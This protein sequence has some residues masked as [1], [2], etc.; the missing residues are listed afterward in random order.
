MLHRSKGE[1]GAVAV[2]VAIC[3]VLLVSFAAIAVDMGLWLTARRQLQSAADSAALAGCRELA[4]GGSDAAVW[5]TVVDYAGRNFTVPVRLAD[6]VVVDP[7]PGG[8]SDIGSDYVKVTVRTV[9]P[10][11][12]ARV[13]GHDEG[14]VAAQSVARIGYL[15]GGR[16]PVPWGL[17][18]LHVGTMTASMGG[19]TV[20]LW[21]SGSGTW[22]GAFSAGGSGPVT[23]RATN[24]VGY[25]EEFPSVV[26]VGTLPAGGR[27]AAVNLE[28]TTFTSGVNSTCRVEVTLASALAQGGKVEASTGGAAVALV[29][30][31]ATGRYV[32]TVD[33]PGTS[34]AFVAQ[35]VTVIVKEGKDTQTAQAK[36]LVRRANFILQDVEVEPAFAGPSDAVSVRV[37]TLEFDYGTQYQLKVEGGT[38]TTGNFLALDFAQT[39]LEHSLCGFP[40][41]PVSPGGHGA[42]DYED[43]IVGDP[44]LIVHLNDLVDTKTGDMTGPTR[45][46]LSDRLAGVSLLTFAQWEAAGE[47]ETKQ[48]LLVPITEKIEDQTGKSQLKIISFATFFIE[49]APHSSKDPVVGRFVEYTAPGWVVTNNPPG[50]LS[51]KAVHL[52][53]D[54]L[55][56]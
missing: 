55:D 12:F 31:S 53:A 44:N 41:T 24:S 43:Y 27:I 37:K 30:D 23:V 4:H 8:L 54:H 5:S 3:L 6:S 36:V 20:E 34:D 25:T 29:L 15:A 9:S 56:F 46:G 13:M 42:S 11:F 48:L 7:T 38:G 16:G 33:I 50:A 17:S 19:Q 18:V 14:R 51:I 39:S 26:A 52:V 32:G 10:S 35:P 22:R 40:D 21:D 45:T 2:I 47:P 1:D 49:E 28:R